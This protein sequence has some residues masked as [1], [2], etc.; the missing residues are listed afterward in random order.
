MITQELRIGNY[1]KYNDKIIIVDTIYYDSINMDLQDCDGIEINLLKPIP[2]TEEILLKCGFRKLD[3][4]TFV[5]GGL[6]IHSRKLGFVFHLGKRKIILSSLHQ[7]QNLYFALTNKEL[8]IN[9]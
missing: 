1:I 8:E 9:L 3:K 4:Y 5:I 6:F 7:L 2:L